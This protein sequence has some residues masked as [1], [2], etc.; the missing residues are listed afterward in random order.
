MACRRRRSRC[1]ACGSLLVAADVPKKAR[2][3]TAVFIVYINH[4]IPAMLV[5][6]TEVLFHAMCGWDVRARYRTCGRS[7][8]CSMH[9]TPCELV[10]G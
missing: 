2:G 6:S 3:G 7:F 5:S 8:R 1:R 9:G 10:P 4:N